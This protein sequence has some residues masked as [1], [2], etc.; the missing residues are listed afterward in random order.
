MKNLKLLGRLQASDMVTLLLK[1]NPGE[2]LEYYILAKSTNYSIIASGK[3]NG[4]VGGGMRM[5]NISLS[6]LLPMIEKGVSMRITYESNVLSFVSQDDRV[7]LTPLCVEYNDPNAHAIIDKFLRFLDATTASRETANKIHKMEN[8]IEEITNK[9]SNVN[10]M[11]LEG[12]MTSSNPFGTAPSTPAVDDAELESKKEK[13]AQLHQDSLLLQRVD[14]KPFKAMA[15]AAARSREMVSFCDDY[16]ITSL[17]ST[18]ILQRGK[19]PPMAILGTLLYNL[20]N[21]GDGE[22]FFW[23]EN[24][25]VYTTGDQE[26]TTVFLEKFLPNTQVDSSIVT[27]GAVLEKYVLNMKNVLSITQLMKSKFPRMLFDMGEGQ[28]VLDNDRNETLTAKFD[29]ADAQT[30]QLKKLMR[31]ED[32]QGSIH[33]AKIVIPP[34]VQALLSLF[35]GEVTIYIKQRKIVFQSD[36]LYLVFGR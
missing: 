13:L 9:E 1:T 21:H 11:D 19:C 22:G 16:A 10:L 35:R 12:A 31:G 27:R 25:L 8:E 20:I 18:Y 7:K 3:C 30:L 2:Q 5:F 28:L 4:D 32:V 34:E 6:S 23:F 15:L 36:T 26:K 24:G 33:M 14:M 29:V 17:K